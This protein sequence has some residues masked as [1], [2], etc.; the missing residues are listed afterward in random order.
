MNDGNKYDFLRELKAVDDKKISEIARKYPV[1]DK[2]ALKRINALCEEKLKMKENNV[3]NINENEEQGKVE[4]VRNMPWY[5]NP[6]LTSTACFA[7]ILGS[8]I[9]IMTL[10]NGKERV[11]NIPDNPPITA[12]ETTTET[13]AAETTVDSTSVMTADIQTT[14][15]APENNSGEMKMPELI[16]KSFSS[17]ESEYKDYF[18]VVADS[19]EYNEN[20]EAGIIIAQDIQ[21]DTNISVGSIVKVVVSQGVNTQTEAP[22][23]SPAEITTWE[24]IVPNA[25]G[26]TAEDAEKLINAVN[27]AEQLRANASGV[28]YDMEDSFTDDNG[29]LYVRITEEGFNTIDD[30]RR[31]LETYITPDAI[32]KYYGSF[33]DGSGMLVENNGLYVRYRP[34]SVGFQRVGEIIA[35]TSDDEIF[36]VI[37][38]IDDFGTEN[39]VELKVYYHEAGCRVMDIIYGR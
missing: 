16:G 37:V 2:D 36:S 23:E 33:F 39:S 7:V 18:T 22:T 34:T 1:P 24:E 38:F 28:A 12:V 6:W 3:E 10:F 15:A 31:Y 5:G 26:L 30:V 9:G 11:P 27:F 25:E 14:T 17:V 13:A 29:Q 21:P 32:E 4:V 20:Y 19:Y 35:K 8:T